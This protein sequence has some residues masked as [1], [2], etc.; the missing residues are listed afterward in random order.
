M[1]AKHHKN[2]PLHKQWYQSVT[3]VSQQSTTLVTLRWGS[4]LLTGA[5]ILFDGQCGLS[6]PLWCFELVRTS[7][8]VMPE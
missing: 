5:C 7:V 4:A 1:H 3:T 8:V 6:T 2:V